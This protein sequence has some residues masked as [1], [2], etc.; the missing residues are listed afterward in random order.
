MRHSISIVLLLYNE[1]EG[2]KS[3]LKSLIPLLKKT[4][5]DYEII[6][7]ESGSTD[8]SGEMADNEVKKNK[9]IKVIHQGSRKGY[10]NALIEGLKHCG[11][12]LSMYI[13]CDHPYDFVYLTEAVKY[14]GKYDA[15]IGYKQGKRETFGRLVLSKGANLFSKVLFRLNVKDANFP[16]K[17]MKTKFVKRMNLL[18]NNSFIAAEI[19]IELKKQHAKIKEMLVPHKIRTHGQSKFMDFNKVITDHLIDMMRCLR[20]SL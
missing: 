10:G 17:M 3:T 14:I 2:I 13:D 16:F 7:V 12:D 5:S 6:I 18:S 11:K 1:E 19:L 9:K 20:K 8:K 4:F 15:V